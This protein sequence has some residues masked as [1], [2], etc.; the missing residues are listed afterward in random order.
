MSRIYLF[1]I[2]AAL[3]LSA[4]SSDKFNSSWK[5]SEINIDGN[6]SDWS[7][8]PMN[9]VEDMQIM[10]GVI[11]DAQNMDVVIRFSDHRLARH[12]GMRGVTFWFDGENDRTAGFHYADETIPRSRE[13]FSREQSTQPQSNY[14]P[15]GSFT[16]KFSKETDER[17]LISDEP[18]FEA[19][20]G[21]NEGLYSLEMRMPLLYFT[22][23]LK[24]QNVLEATI[25]LDEF[26]RPEQPGRRGGP[27]QGGMMGGGGGMGGRRGGMRGG[28]APSE[29]GGISDVKLK[30]ILAS[31]DQ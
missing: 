6:S 30:I 12:L 3:F 29:P 22:E 16:L 15:S 14:I 19:A 25:V 10:Y 21:E 9:Y 28:D 17:I 20:F 2:S 31:K 13:Q 7:G 23:S 11:N 26:E 18:D 8:I 24:D 27:P 5:Q 1:L 4:C